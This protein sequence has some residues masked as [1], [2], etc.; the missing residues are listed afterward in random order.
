[1]SG[2]GGLNF[3]TCALTPCFQALGTRVHTRSQVLRISTG[4]TLP[5]SCNVPTGAF[6]TLGGRYLQEAQPE[7]PDEFQLYFNRPFFPA[8]IVLLEIKEAFLPELPDFYART[9]ALI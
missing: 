5:S 2:L 8:S 3:L 6:P 1:M 7:G 4:R 9:E